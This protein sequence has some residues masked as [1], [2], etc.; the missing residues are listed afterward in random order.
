MSERI[1]KEANLQQSPSGIPGALALRAV[2]LI[3]A[4]AG[5]GLGAV[6]GVS[7]ASLRFGGE[8]PTFWDRCVGAALGLLPGATFGAAVASLAL[9]VWCSLVLWVAVLWDLLRAAVRWTAEL[10]SGRGG[11]ATGA[12]MAIG[13]LT[14]AIC[15]CL[16][17]LFAGSFRLRGPSVPLSDCW[18]TALAC[19]VVGALGALVLCAFACLICCAVDRLFGSCTRGERRREEES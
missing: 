13:G 18:P 8:P 4:L 15:G 12:V 14:G 16:V 19:A 1:R 2:V 9:A 7:L 5:A 11:N 10:V 3:G 17:G 6:L